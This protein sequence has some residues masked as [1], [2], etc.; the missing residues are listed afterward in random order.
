MDSILT[1]NWECFVN[2]AKHLALPV[3]TLGVINE[4]SD[5]ENDQLNNDRSVRF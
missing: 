3:I 1:G 4:C 5:N 2:A